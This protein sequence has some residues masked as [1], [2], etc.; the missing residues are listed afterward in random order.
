MADN[1]DKS[2][3][4]VEEKLPEE[5]PEKMIWDMVEFARTLER[6]MFGNG[7][8]N[9][10]YTPDLMNQRLKD[11]SYNP[12]AADETAL[13]AAL[14][15][16]KTSE[17]FLRTFSENLELTSMPYKRLMSYLGNLLSWDYAIHC[18]NADEKDFKTPAYQKERDKVY[19]FFDKFNVKQE[20]NTAVK[21]MLRNDAF[22]FVF[23]GPSEG[24][25]KYI[26]QELD[27]YYCRITGRFDYGLMYDFDMVRN[28]PL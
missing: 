22:F 10:V 6:G 20:F 24:G 18:T 15:N 7:F 11:I 13:N 19:D 12:R 26:L 14:Q 9:S 27:N 16:P 1:D 17:D 23:R 2:I 25:D 3:E 5:I 8:G 4:K 28:C 21:Q